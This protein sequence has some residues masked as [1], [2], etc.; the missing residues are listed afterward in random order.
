MKT[1]TKIIGWRACIVLV[2]LSLNTIS[3][4]KI[5]NQPSNT[6]VATDYS[7]ASHWL[8]IPANL[9]PVDIFYYYP[10]SWNKLNPTCRVLY[11]IAEKSA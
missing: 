11:K 5:D 10:S 3:C 7:I 1:E 8:S 4:N 2:A 6:D 9:S